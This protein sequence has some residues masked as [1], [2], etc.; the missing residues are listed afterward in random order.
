MDLF[1]VGSSLERDILVD[2]EQVDDWRVKVLG[3]ARYDTLYNM[4]RENEQLQIIY[5]PTHRNYIR[6]K[7][8]KSRF[9]TAV[10][11]FLANKEVMKVLDENNIQL[12]LYLHK[13][14]QKYSNLYE[15]E[16]SNIAIIQLGEET[17]KEL[18]MQSHLMITDY[19][20]VSWDFFYLGKPVL[21]YRFDVD[22]CLGDRGSYID[23]DD[24]R[25]GEIFYD[26]DSLVCA[27]HD[28]VKNGFVMKDRNMRYRTQILPNID[29]SNC[30]R[31]FKEVERIG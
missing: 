29:T 11:S 22:E 9:F 25:V 4:A 15:G 2:E 27:I 17:P 18:I 5:I 3:Y 20:S 16:S 31:I 24:D 7:F 30:S 12:K 8:T 28:Y 19:S 10:K 23:L 21:F 1:T 14:F 6:S 26:E 13:E